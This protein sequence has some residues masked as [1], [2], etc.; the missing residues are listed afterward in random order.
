MARN[1]FGGTAADSAENESG[2]RLPNLKG[3]V[4]AS[5]DSPDLVTDLLD[6]SGNALKD[7]LLTDERGM[8]PPFQ[9]PDGVEQLW[10]DFNAGRVMLTPNNVGKR[11][12]AHVSDLDPHGSMAYTNE[13]L[14]EVMKRDSNEVPLPSNRRWLGLLNTTESPGGD[15]IYQSN[16]AETHNFILRKDGSMTLY[17]HTNNHVP[18]EL[19]AGAAVNEYALVIN[20]S[21]FDGGNG[22]FKIDWRGTITSGGDIK[23]GGNIAASGTVTASNIGTARVFSGTVDPASQGVALKPGDIWVQYGS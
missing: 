2:G 15:T 3:R 17:Q 10:V 22:A 7:G 16:G 6:A 11:L 19:S 9:G 5:A 12:S 4:Y 21:K 23:A 20:G 13:R 1:Y 14:T 18:L 8:I